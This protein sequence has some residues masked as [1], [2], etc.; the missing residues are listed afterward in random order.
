MKTFFMGALAP[1]DAAQ[2][3]A[4]LEAFCQHF[5]E[6][7]SAADTAVTHYTPAAAHDL[8]PL[9]WEMTVDYGRRYTQMIAEWSHD[10][11]V[12]LAQARSLEEGSVR[13]RGESSL[14]HPA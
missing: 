10:C 12:R 3:F 4:E 2:H 8:D 9:F 1:E 5:Y 7:L 14:A 13:H 11:Q 6:G